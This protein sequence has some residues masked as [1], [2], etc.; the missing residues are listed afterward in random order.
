M[1]NNFPFIYNTEEE[2]GMEVRV[3]NSSQDKGKGRTPVSGLY[4]TS[5]IR[6]EFLAGGA[7]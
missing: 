6:R 4:A 1:L 2:E 3:E 5:V 7:R